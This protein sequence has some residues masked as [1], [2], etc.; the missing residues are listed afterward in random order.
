MY[1][2]TYNITVFNISL[3]TKL[4]NLSENEKIVIASIQGDIPISSR[5]YLALSEKVGLTEDEFIEILKGLREKGVIR[6]FGATLKHQKSGFAAN[7]MVAWK[8]PE[9]DMAATGKKM[10]S[11]SAVSHC[12]RRSPQ[13]DW[14]YNLYTMVHAADENDC[15]RTV[16][17]LSEMSGVS[18]FEL[19]FSV[20]E[21]KKTS[22]KYFIN[23]PQESMEDEDD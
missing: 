6:R 8:A 14:D 16:K 22:M 19:L 13:L 4:V 23:A 1:E 18:D 7:A 11:S 9:S 17:D 20:R 2:L 15:L 10:A 3:R 5:P 21:L 12:Y